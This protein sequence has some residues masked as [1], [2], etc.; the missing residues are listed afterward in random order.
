MTPTA[1]KLMRNALRQQ[2]RWPGQLAGRVEGKRVTA[3]TSRLL[4]TSPTTDGTHTHLCQQ[5][6]GRTSHQND[7]GWDSVMI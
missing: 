7:G 3:H 1:L 4:S 5:L 2:Q 6:T